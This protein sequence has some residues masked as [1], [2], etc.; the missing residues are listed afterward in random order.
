MLNFLEITLRHEA[1]PARGIS[2]YVEI[3]I[4]GKAWADIL[5][6]D[7]FFHAIEQSGRYPLFT[8]QCGCFGCSGY[9]VDVEC[10]ENEWILRNKFDPLSEEMV[11][12]SEYRISWR[13][14]YTVATKLRDFIRKY[15]IEQGT[16]R[17]SSGA[18]GF[19]AA[20]D[21]L[22]GKDLI[23]L[24]EVSGGVD[25]AKFERYLSLVKAEAK[26]LGKEFYFYSEESCSVRWEEKG[27]EMASLSGWLLEPE[28]MKEFLYWIDAYHQENDIQELSQKYFSKLRGV[29]WAVSKS[30][31]LSIFFTEEEGFADFGV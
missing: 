28:E 7:E 17:I 13:N 23:S 10:A 12:E 21:L 26:R 22:E 25:T 30:G 19:F 31:D 24:R 4:D 2:L 11:E 5:D 14:I 8:C 3:Y 16:E 29:E 27:L 9:Y 20:R 6:I 18:S 15:C 1:S